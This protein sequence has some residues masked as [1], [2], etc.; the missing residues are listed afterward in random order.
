[1]LSEKNRLKVFALLALL[2]MLSVSTALGAP[3]QGDFDCDRDV[4]GTDATTF[5]NDFGRSQFNNPCDPCYIPVPVSKTGQTTSYTTGDDGHLQRG[6]AL[7][8]P[9]F[10]DHG[11]GTVT[12]NLTGLI[13]TKNAQQIPGIMNWQAALTACNDLDFAGY[14]DWRLPNIRELQSLVDYGE[15]DPALSLG[16][17]F[18]N[19]IAINY[20]SSTT[21]ESNSDNA[22]CVSISFGYV[23]YYNKITIYFVWP[24]RGG[25]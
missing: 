24:V 13:W 14:T 20:W 16:Y 12:D 22:W 3:C 1:M 5:K 4:D 2:F 9:R 8:N 6:V 17:P 18:D 21:Y 10:T 25:Q 11:D 19:V 23:Y 7:P 15:A